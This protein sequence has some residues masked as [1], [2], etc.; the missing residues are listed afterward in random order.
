MS[1]LLNSK[2]ASPG[3]G[4]ADTETRHKYITDLIR[5]GRGELEIDAPVV[6]RPMPEKYR[7]DFDGEQLDA[8]VMW[9]GNGYVIY[10][11]KNLQDYKLAKIIAH[12]LIHV[13]QYETGKMVIC[14]HHVEFD[15][16]VY[17]R[18]K[19]IDYEL[20]PWEREAFAK[21]FQLS[22]KLKILVSEDPKHEKE[23]R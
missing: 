16:R 5:V 9:K 8:C 1:A 10:L 3:L 12:E 20:R 14:D 11:K 19:Q 15:G 17:K 21:S 6:Y 4:G 23:K 18:P 2:V 22:R 13:W 7:V